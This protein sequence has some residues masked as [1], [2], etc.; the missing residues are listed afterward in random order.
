MRD[1]MD[2]FTVMKITDGGSVAFFRARSVAMAAYHL[3]LEQLKRR[4]R[5]RLSS[6]ALRKRWRLEGDGGRH[7]RPGDARNRTAG[8]QRPS[9][10]RRHRRRGKADDRIAEQEG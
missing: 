3:H 1:A 4:V 6:A 10:E 5:N 9:D 8:S 2:G 7:G